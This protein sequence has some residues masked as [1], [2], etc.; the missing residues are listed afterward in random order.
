MSHELLHPESLSLI[1]VLLLA[2]GTLWKKL[3]AKEKQV[4]AMIEELVRHSD[5]IEDLEKALDRLA[6]EV[7]SLGPSE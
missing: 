6:L 4:E 3:Q 2:V 1:G 5:I 7:R